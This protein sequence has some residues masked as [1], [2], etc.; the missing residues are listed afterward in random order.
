MRKEDRKWKMLNDNIYPAHTEATTSDIANTLVSAIKDDF[1]LG[2][3]T[4]WKARTLNVFGKELT[5]FLGPLIINTSTGEWLK[6][7]FVCNYDDCIHKM[8][9]EMADMI[10]FIPEKGPPPP[11]YSFISA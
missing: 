2:C 5:K 9:E 10:Y 8:G 4:R 11:E 6:W 7:D 1:V 3:L